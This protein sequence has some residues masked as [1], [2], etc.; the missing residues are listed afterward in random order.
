MKKRIAFLLL[1]AV[2]L[3]LSSCNGEGNGMDARFSMKATVEAV[4]EKIQ[5]NVTEADYAYGIHLVITAAETEYIGKNGERIERADIHP[6]ATVEIRYSGQ[7]M[8]S[9][10]PQIVAARITLL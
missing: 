8:M 3:S 4:G 5:V 6:G 9:Y 1:L 2:L 7:V 10:P